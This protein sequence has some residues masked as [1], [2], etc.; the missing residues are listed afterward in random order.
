MDSAVEIVPAEE[1][2]IPGI[3]SCWK[4]LMDF[5]ET[6]DAFYTQSP[7]GYIHFEALIRDYL[8]S[9]EAHIAVAL[10]QDAVVGYA[11]C[12]IHSFPPIFLQKCCGYI[13]DLVVRSEYR[14]RGIGTQL[15]DSLYEWFRVQGIHGLRLRV[16]AHNRIGLS[17]W[18]KQGFE[19][20]IYVLYRALE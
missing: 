8:K 5:H 10:H 17:F 12:H 16:S 4:E 9:K 15:L 19:K 11:T 1:H 14:R 7:D 6:I 20:R 13:A 2:H 18:E 3:I